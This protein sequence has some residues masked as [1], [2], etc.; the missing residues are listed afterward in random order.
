[1]C[2]CVR[3][4]MIFVASNEEENIKRTKMEEKMKDEK[5]SGSWI[6]RFDPI[7]TIPIWMKRKAGRKGCSFLFFF[8]FF[9]FPTHE[10]NEKALLFL[11]RS[12]AVK[13]Y[14]LFVYSFGPRDG[15]GRRGEVVGWG[16]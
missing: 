1:M 6:T 4:G 2:A 15:G 12:E 3:V 5:R 16:K 9:F 13:R 14:T 7:F 11:A 10:R 8:L